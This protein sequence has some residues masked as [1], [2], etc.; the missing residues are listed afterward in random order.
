MAF[1]FSAIRLL[2]R[3]HAKR[4][5]EGPILTLGRQGIFGTLDQCRNVIRSQGLDPH[6]LPQ[7]LVTGPN[8]PAFKSDLYRNFTNDACVFWMMCGQVPETLDVSDYEDA[9]H[10]HD[11]NTPIPDELRGRFSVIIDGGTLEHVFDIP[12][13]LRN[14]KAMLRPG[15]RIIHLN[16]TNNWAEHGFY[17]LSPTLYHDFYAVNGFEMLDCLIVELSPASAE[18]LFKRRCPVWRWTP[19][20]PSAPIISRNMLSLYF[21]SVKRSEVAD[22]SPQQGECAGGASSSQL[23]GVKGKPGFL[24]KARTMALGISPM[25]GSVV[26]LGKRLL[27]RDLSSKPWGMEYVGRF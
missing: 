18:G 7:D 1:T 20:R 22:R 23:G 19:D 27:R 10:I 11:L 6:I 24:N 26:L 17:Q 9:D 16:P 13:A 15:G 21:E 12:Q 14:L 2:A 4:P 3:S 25:A 8:V 5:F